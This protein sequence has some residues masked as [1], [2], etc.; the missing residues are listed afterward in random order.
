MP[1]P[2]STHYPVYLQIPPLNISSFVF[3]TTSSK[4]RRTCNAGS[5]MPVSNQ[6]TNP[7]IVESAW[8]LTKSCWYCAHL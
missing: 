2:P 3:L 7:S 5:S 1:S 8:P 6:A 4:A